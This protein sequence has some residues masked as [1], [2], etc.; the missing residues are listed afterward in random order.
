MKATNAGEL[1]NLGNFT[2]DNYHNTFAFITQKQSAALSII[3][4]SFIIMCRPESL[5]SGYCKRRT[6]S[7]SQF[8]HVSIAHVCGDTEHFYTT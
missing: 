3:D 2:K 8:V 5:P 4:I 1:Q 6:V 7:T